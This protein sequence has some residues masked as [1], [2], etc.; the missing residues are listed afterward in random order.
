MITDVM[1]IGGG[2]SGLRAATELDARGID[3]LVLEARDRFGGRILSKSGVGK[4]NLY[5]LGPAWLWPGQPRMIK[6]IADL[7]LQVF[8]QHAN[9]R[10]V[11]QDRDGSVRRDLSFTTM[12]GSLRVAGGMAQVVDGMADR[13]AHSRLLKG[14]A[15]T[16]LIR[17]SAGIEAIA[18][19]HGVETSIKARCAVLAIPPRVAV[20]TIK[21]DPDPGTAARGA[22]KGVPTWMAGQAKLIAIYDR[23]FWREAGLSGDGISHKGPLFEIHDASP[24]SGDE[25][26]LFGFVGR[27]AIHRRGNSSSLVEASIAQLTTMF[28]EQ[29]NSPIDVISHDWAT[30]A[31]TAR[32]ADADISAT[33]PG[34]GM[35]GALA[36]LWDGR[37]AFASTEVARSFGGLMEGALEAAEQA[38]KSLMLRDP[39]RLSSTA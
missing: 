23:P 13:L 10:V 35:P 34:Y 3:Y 26:A 36:R 14:H 9:G 38:I 19:H 15:V 6:L 7:G 1:I 16:N 22:M 27:P 21:F 31:Y 33:H 37:L 5:D 28:G 8:E 24:V 32:D 4:D 20:E 12:K 18:Y 30:E 2:L 25:S 39:H 29:A 11:F 17:S